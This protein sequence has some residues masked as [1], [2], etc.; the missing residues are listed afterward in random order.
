MRT[1][2]Y[3]RS[4]R[5]VRA[6]SILHSVQIRAHWIFLV[7]FLLVAGGN[8]RATTPSDGRSGVMN[9]TANS[10]RA[11]GD[12]VST[13]LRTLPQRAGLWITA[14]ELADLPM[15]GPAWDKLKTEADTPTGIPDL[16][17]Q[18]DPTNVRVLAKALVYARSHDENYRTQ[19]IDAVMAAMGTEVV[20]ET[21][22]LGRELAAY[23]IAAD[24]V[25]MPYDADQQFRTWL[26]YVLTETLQATTL[27]LTHEIRPNNWGTH[28]GASRAAIAVY[29]GDDVE[30]E[31]TAQVFK[32]YLGDRSVYSGFDYGDLA[33]Q[34]DPNNPVGIN[35]LGAV[36][37]GYS[38][39]GAIPD[40]MRRGG[41]FRWPPRRT[42]YPWGA[43]QGA[44][45][46][47]EILHRAG[48]DT[49]N[50]GDKA[51]LRATQ[52]LYSIHW[53]ATGDETW[54]PWII[55]KIY[56]TTFHATSPATP[57]K[58]MAWTDW[59]HAN[60][61]VNPHANTTP[62]ASNADDPAIWVH[63]NDPSQSV[64]I[65]TD[66]GDSPNGGL[67]VWN[68]DGSQHQYLS[69]NHPNNVDVRYGMVLSD[70]Y[71]DIAA[72]TM[73]NN[74]EIRI[75]KIDPQTRT[76]SDITTDGGIPVYSDPYGICL[77][78]RPSDG[79]MFAI[80]SSARHSNNTLWQLLLEDDGTGKV[81]GTKVREFGTITDVMEGMVADDELGYVYISEEG[82][83]VH[84][85]Y[86]D[87]S[88]GDERLALFAAADAINGDRE[89]LAIYKCPEGTG[90]ILLS[91]QGNSTVK[92]YPRE[93]DP[94]NPHQHILITTIE[95][96]GSTATDG[97]D[98]TNR[99]TSPAFPHG[100]L[101]K[102]NSPGNNFIL[103]AWEDLAQDG[104]KIC[105]EA[106]S[107]PVEL[108]VFTAQSQGQEVYL[109]WST[110][111]ES[112]NLG[113]EVQRRDA[114]R[115]FSRL[116][117]VPGYGTTTESHSYSY[118]DHDLGLGSYAYRLKQ[119]DTDGSFTY[120][121]EVQVEMSA[122]RE[123][124]L[125]E[126]YPNPFSVQTLIRLQLPQPDKVQLVVY[127]LL[128]REVKRIV[129]ERLSAGYQ[130]FAWDGR[131]NLGNL[132]PN[133]VYFYKLITPTFSSTR[134]M[135]L[136]R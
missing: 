101:V 29:L 103:Y 26:R 60:F 15:S 102:H 18:D 22:A 133:G 109:R 78:K 108:A 95:T 4:A 134:K 127:N 88:M 100:F 47:A 94:G 52:F 112:N 2:K 107:V 6:G 119:I 77:Y 61:T 63:P 46:Q 44:A 73:R 21:L 36:K 28:A 115:E 24:L 31:R 128:G 56:G 121:S 113:F 131:D 111:T 92:I 83:G 85:H 69:I 23:V 80:I 129:D 33:W 16:A 62:V 34:A 116:A 8:V 97:L 39:D 10:F 93:G 91:S 5:S 104:L 57:G 50:W 96:I 40:D 122:P 123:F 82:V 124:A 90:Y 125:Q 51:L 54:V 64:I 27:Q 55:D 1:M 7:F 72:A 48:Y 79:A 126:N 53:P 132:A 45:V 43:M 11:Q 71:V 135:I 17:N 98:V 35:P 84:K 117:F 25:G 136:I 42:N 65:G 58:N 59:T 118:V 12:S 99:L 32:G 9:A 105:D 114:H 66:K 86:A 38:I 49:W 67:F 41:G 87:P 75:F 89:G 130:S 76:L 13:S 106:L 74:N 20:G 37:N 110:S 68:M 120:S 30:L 19:V 3:L 14:A 81:K 70:A